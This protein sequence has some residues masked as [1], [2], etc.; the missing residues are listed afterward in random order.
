MFNSEFYVINSYFKWSELSG[1][2]QMLKF[3]LADGSWKTYEMKVNNKSKPGICIFGFL[4]SKKW[5]TVAYVSILSGLGFACE[6]M[7][8]E[9]E[10]NSTSKSYKK[11]KKN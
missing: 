4:G 11:K 6:N 2:V 8:G 9:V 7:E 1:H 5:Q 3:L 10:K